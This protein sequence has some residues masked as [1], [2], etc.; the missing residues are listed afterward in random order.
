MTIDDSSQDE[1]IVDSI[2]SFH[3]CA[4]KDLFDKYKPCVVGDVVMTNDLGRKVIGPG[5][6]KMKIFDRVF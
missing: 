4:I 5:I 6:V 3:M 1:W 2:C